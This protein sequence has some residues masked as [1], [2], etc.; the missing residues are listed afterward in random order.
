MFFKA[1]TEFYFANTICLYEK[2][3]GIGQ[4]TM[5]HL[6]YPFIAILYFS[7][8]LHSLIIGFLGVIK[9]FDCYFPVPCLI[10]LY[11]IRSPD[12]LLR[13]QKQYFSFPFSSNFANMFMPFHLQSILYF[14]C[15]PGNCTLA[16][17]PIF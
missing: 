11:I 4:F 14:F 5:D 7:I 13:F 16:L 9:K 1:H 10:C 17:L 6:L 12:I 2:Y 8:V 3:P 15:S